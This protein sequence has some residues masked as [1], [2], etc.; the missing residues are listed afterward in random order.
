VRVGVCEKDRDLMR[1]KETESERGTDRL[2]VGKRAT[3]GQSNSKKDRWRNRETDKQIGRHRHTD[4]QTHRH[5]DT[6]THGHTDTQTYRH[7][8]TP[9]RGHARK[10]P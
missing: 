1:E 3:H 6:Q 2:A 10:S 7:T 5:T 4:T 9:Q 8:D